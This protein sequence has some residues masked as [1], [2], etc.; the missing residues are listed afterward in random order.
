MS[1]ATT[2]ASPAR[3][4][5][6]TFAFDDDAVGAGAAVALA[7]DAFARLERDEGPALEGCSGRIMVVWESRRADAEVA[8]VACARV[9]RA[10]EQTRVASSGLAR[11][12]QKFSWPFSFPRASS[13]EAL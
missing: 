9:S 12:D 6:D 2:Y 13:V 3:A 4:R 5:E 8:E 1:R 10:G 7:D 11:N